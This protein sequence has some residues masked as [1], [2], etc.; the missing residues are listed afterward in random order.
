MPKI[1]D[2]VHDYGEEVQV[3]W[4]NTRISYGVPGTRAVGLNLAVNLVDLERVPPAIREEL[5]GCRLFLLDPE[6][7]WMDKGNM[8]ETGLAFACPL[9]QAAAICDL[10]RE[11]D[12]RAGQTPTRVYLRKVKAWTKLAG[13]AIL[14]KFNRLNPDVFPPERAVAVTPVFPTKPAFPM[15]ARKP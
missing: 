12:H 14:V 1:L 7:I 15:K 5:F 6:P 9:M 4:E 13:D 10:L 11:H 8:E 3:S 2:G